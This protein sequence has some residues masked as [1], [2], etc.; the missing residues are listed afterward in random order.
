MV[1]SFWDAAV[2]GADPIET[3]DGFAA[4]L[5]HCAAEGV[6][7]VLVEDAS[8]FARSMVAQELGVMLLAKRGVRLITASGQELSD[9]SDPSKVMIRQVFGALNQYEK[10]KI[11]DRLRKG[12][13]R[14]IAETGRCGGV[15]GWEDR[16]PALVREAKRLARKSPKTGKARSYRQIG[17]ELAALGFLSARGTAL[18]PSVVKNLVG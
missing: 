9:D 17:S 4:L 8:R 12:R 11:V 5:E 13:D 14:K 10:A 2:S 7:T 18:S 3:R 16:S 6:A 1:S 15:V